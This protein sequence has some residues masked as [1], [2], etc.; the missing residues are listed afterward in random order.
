MADWDVDTELFYSGGWQSAEAYT[1]DG[2]TIS[3]GLA[4]E[5]LEAQPGAASLTLDNRDGSK[6]PNN[7]VS[8]LYGLVGRNTPLRV[9]VDSSVRLSCEVADWLP[10]RTLVPVDTV[11][12]RGDAWT[13]VAGAGI[14]RR[15]G[16][17]KT[18][19]KSPAWRALIDPAND[20]DRIAWWPLEDEQDVVTPLSPVGSPPV[21]STFLT[22]PPTWGAYTKSPS[23]ERMVT[24]GTGSLNFTV[25]YYSS[26]QHKV[27]LLCHLPWD[28][29]YDGIDLVRLNCT[30]CVIFVR[31]KLGG[32]LDTQAWNLS[33]S[34]LL[35]STGAVTFDAI[36]K[37]FALILE[38]PQNG[39]NVDL[40]IRVVPMSGNGL[41]HFDVLNGVTV[42]RIETIKLVAPQGSLGHLAVADS[43]GAF[44]NYLGSDG[45]P[46]AVQGW[47]G[48]P[49]AERFDRIC[50]ENDIAGTVVGTA[51]DSQAMGVQPTATL[52]DVLKECARSDSGLLYESRA[53]LGLS[54]RTGRDLYAHGAGGLP[55][56]T[57]DYA[58][59]EV[60]PTLEPV[61][62]DQGTRNDVIAKR[63]NGSSQRAVL[64][65]GRM[66]VLDPPA[67]VGRYDTSL[68]VNIETDARLLDHATWHLRKGTVDETRYRSVTVDLDA[69][70]AT[71]ALVAAVNLV[72]IG[73]RIAITNLPQDESPD[74]A[75]LLVI[76]ISESLPPKRRLVTFTTI[77]ASPYDVA[78]VGAN[79]GSTN[80][81]GQA[82]DTDHSTLAA[83]VPA[84]QPGAT[85]TL[86][87]ASTGGVLWTTDANDWSTI[88]NG[89]S[90][91]GTGLFIRI[92]GEDMRVTSIAGAGSPQTFTVVR[93]VN[94]VVKAHLSGAAVHARYPVVVGL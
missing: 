77:P 48:E 38:L 73:D 9:A 8:P 7:P 66:S 18:P 78:T 55:V 3:R 79:D 76:A 63:R 71:P 19:L 62:G 83:D 24:M 1:R 31:W 36:G 44:S 26:S 17:G 51:S 21:V 49:A 22:S 89:T 82:V 59:G 50:D 37:E 52:T 43:T 74:D 86:S 34:A 23:A 39:A 61:I 53:A 56:L 75:S 72:D 69:P 58:A 35:D 92:G 84:A 13:K 28:D 45:S 10:G 54:F 29:T 64:E 12:Q 15:L 67:G 57:L 25:P 80:L 4:D 42:G 40:S 2:M 41:N 32:A 47:L 87:V 27:I 30:S 14:L 11:R 88:R 90:T 33:G 65:S 68:D 6:N 91:D 94:G 85:S 46:R 20:A 60:A 5:T 70:S 93:A 81:R 16:R